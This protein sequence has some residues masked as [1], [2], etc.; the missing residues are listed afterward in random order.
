MTF[1]DTYNQSVLPGVIPDSV[2]HLSFGTDFNQLLLPK[3]IPNSVTHMSLDRDFNTVIVPGVLPDSLT[4]LQFH[5]QFSVFNQPLLA[6]EAKIPS[7]DGSSDEFVVLRSIPS[8]V[9]HLILGYGYNQSLVLPPS[10][11]HLALGM[12]FCQKLSVALLPAGLKELFVTEDTEVDMTDLHCEVRIVGS[13][14]A[15]D[16]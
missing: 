16:W 7:S 5:R 14:E 4:C 6:V 12:G 10:V 3:S 2:T 13:W 15:I 8:S 9:T 11:T 1:G